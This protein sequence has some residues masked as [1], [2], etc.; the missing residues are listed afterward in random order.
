MYTYIYVYVY[1][2]AR[3]DNES[4]KE[5]AIIHHDVTCFHHQYVVRVSC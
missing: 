3:S 2:V 5:V 4:V 1:Y